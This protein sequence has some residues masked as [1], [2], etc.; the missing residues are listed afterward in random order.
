MA[1]LFSEAKELSKQRYMWVVFCTLG[2]FL[3]PEYLAVVSVIVAAV[4]AYKEAKETRHCLHKFGETGRRTTFFICGLLLTLTFST[5]FLSSVA[6]VLMWLA[7]ALIY[8]SLLTVITDKERLCRLF[9]ALTLCLGVLGL[10]SCIQYCGVH[11]FGWGRETLQLWNFLDIPLYGL[12][13][14]GQ[15]FHLMTSPNRA[16]ATYSNPNIF[17]E[18][19]IFLIPLSAYSIQSARHASSRILFSLCLAVGVLGT[20]FSFSRSSYFCL[21]GILF[22]FLM[23]LVPRLKWPWNIILF[24]GSIGLV[25][26]LAKTPNVFAERMQTLSKG[27]GDKSISD[28]TKIWMAAWEAITKRPVFGY[29]AGIQ[30]S[31]QIMA[32]TGLPTVPPHA[33]SLYFQLLIEG[34]AVLLML[35]FL[36]LFNIVYTQWDTLFRKKHQPLLGYSVMVSLAGLLAF[37]LVEYPLMCPKLVGIWWILFAL[38]DLSGAF[39]A[40][41]PLGHLI[42]KKKPVSEQE[43][44][45]PDA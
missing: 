20:G 3:L 1:Y 18:A 31:T 13:F 44:S 7:M 25:I 45:G 36:P 38:S 17:A 10:I 8:L 40:N 43:G 9:Q 23:Y 6:T 30:T 16:A 28:R 11:Y 27:T 2:V 19:M 34:G 4:L 24:V 21:L 39:Y 26:L 37:G 32:D 29:G 33:H 22:L 35:F 12:M 41:L 42:E 15:E 5:A 14:K